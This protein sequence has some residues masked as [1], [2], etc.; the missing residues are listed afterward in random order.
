MISN[1]KQCFITRTN[2]EKRVE[3]A[4]HSGEFLT[5]FEVFVLVMKHCFMFDI[6]LLIKLI[7]NYRENEGI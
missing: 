5:N 6:I 4:T 2:T 7:I 3:N 1:M